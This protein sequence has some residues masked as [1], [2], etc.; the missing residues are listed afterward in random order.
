MLG[1]SIIGTTG[2]GGK[3]VAA[4]VAMLAGSVLPAFPATGMSWTVGTI[5][6]IAG[7]ALGVAL[8]RCPVCKARWFWDALMQPELYKQI[9]SHPECPECSRASA[10]EKEP[11]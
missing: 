9:L 2:Q 1:N 10:T 3:L 8:I 7:Y 6:A 4:L 5:L 11:D